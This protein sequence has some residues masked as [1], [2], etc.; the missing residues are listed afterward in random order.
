MTT[1][2][3]D[4]TIY[5]ADNPDND[6]GR[7]YSAVAR[8]LHWLVAGGIVL[9]FVLGER[10][11]EAGLRQDLPGQ[12]AALAQHKSVGITVL[13]LA[14]LRVCWRFIAPPSG[15][16]ATTY[17]TGAPLRRARLAM[18]MHVALYALLFFL[19]LSGW[20]MSSASG[21]SVSWF[22]LAQLPDLIGPGEDA[23]A[24]LQTLHHWAGKALLVLAIGHIL[25]AFKHWLFDKDDV[26]R[27][28]GNPAGVLVFASTIVAGIAITWPKESPQP[29]RQPAIT[30]EL[31]PAAPATAAR[32][33]VEKELPL[34]NVHKQDSYIRFR[35]QQAGADFTGEWTGFNADIRFAANALQDSSATV[36]I[37]ASML[38]TNDQERDEIL[39]GLDWFDSASFTTVI[40][41]AD[42]I[43]AT[44]DG[45]STEATLKL[46]GT[47]YPV[48]FNFTVS[49][50]KNLHTL[51]GSARLDR[52][53]L[54]LGTIEWADTD[55]VGQFVEVEVQLQAD[56]YQQS[57]EAN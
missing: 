3:S 20:L 5:P 12:L 34:W 1:S 49:S 24:L 38:A 50:T 28:M 21:Y 26:M 4:T 9:Q 54:N 15:A 37:D 31:L 42:Q 7:G 27:R 30:S 19:P 46:R 17:P 18:T 52:L 51:R 47:N 13:G 45:F 43:Q 14:I 6:T 55:W 33:T 41:A 29:H 23:K 44:A 32:L 40:F 35:A 11:E 48:E 8:L 39:A 22:N 57:E 36:R 56:T 2:T 53:D 10:A 25:A 16:I